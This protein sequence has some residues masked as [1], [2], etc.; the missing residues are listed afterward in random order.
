MLEEL[1]RTQLRRI[2]T[3]NRLKRFVKRKNY[4]YSPEDNVP[5]IPKSRP[6]SIEFKTNI[7]L[8]EETIKEFYKEYRTPEEPEYL[9][10]T[11][12]IIKS[13]G[14]VVRILPLPE[15][16]RDKYITFPEKWFEEESNSEEESQHS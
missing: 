12:E 11:Q 10:T 7:K 5:V 2:Y 15:S 16:E 13:T 8:E 9:E 3:R 1:D 6:K 14:T 4:W